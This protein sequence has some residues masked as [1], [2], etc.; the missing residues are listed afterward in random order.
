MPYTYLVSHRPTGLKYYGVRYATHSQP[1]D[2][3][4]SYFT[5]SK[6]VKELI[7]IHGKDSFDYEVRRIFDTAEQA[8]IW[9][10]SVIR[11]MSLIQRPDWLNEGTGSSHQAR[12]R[13]TDEH[14]RKISEAN[15]GKCS[16]KKRKAIIL[17]GEQRK[18]QKLSEETKAKMSQSH[19]Q[20]I[21]IFNPTTNKKTMIKINEIENYPGWI[22]NKRGYRKPTKISNEAKIKM[23]DA[24]KGK[25][26][27]I[28]DPK[29]Q[30]S[31]Q[32]E[33]QMLPKYLEE[34]WILGRKYGMANHSSFSGSPI[35]TLK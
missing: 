24:K 35:I 30:H 14:R 13:K 3:W 16:E 15:K 8:I 10:N 26:K 21:W 29:S 19:T 4:V 12:K 7:S 31:K 28:S 23:S 5:S 27:W 25:V 2:L 32:V 20:K 33:I 1:S 11:R 17:S 9:E 22:A 18:G 6:Q 34:G